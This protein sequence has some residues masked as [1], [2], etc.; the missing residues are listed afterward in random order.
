MLDLLLHTQV[1]HELLK[2]QTK[3]MIFER[4]ILRRIYGPN[5]KADNY[6]RMKISIEIHNLIS[7]WNIVNFIREYKNRRRKRK[8]LPKKWRDLWMK[9][10]HIQ[11]EVSLNHFDDHTCLSQSEESKCML[12]LCVFMCAFHLVISSFFGK[13]FIF[14]SYFCVICTSVLSFPWGL[15]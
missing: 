3:V 4:R 8:L 9:G 1:K 15:L 7:N 11:T 5:T 10:T 13:I 14:L 12:S 2:K 6:W